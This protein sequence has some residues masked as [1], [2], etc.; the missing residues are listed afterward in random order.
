MSP[1][2]RAAVPPCPLAPTYKAHLPCLNATALKRVARLWVGKDASK[3]N[4]DGCIRAIN[5]GLQTPRAVQA[6]LQELTPFERAGLGLLKRY[7]QVAPTDALAAELLMLGIP[8]DER[9][10]GHRSWSV[11]QNVD[12]RALNALLQR[13]AAMMRSWQTSHGYPSDLQLDEYHYSAQ[14][15][16]EPCLLDG[17]DTVP[18]AP[19]P[20]E[21]VRQVETGLAQ[22]PAEVV[23]RLIGMVETLRKLGPI[24]RTAKGRISKPFLV[25][26]TKA[27]GWE[28]AMPQEALAPLAEATQFFFWLLSG[29][30][31]YAPRADGA[32]QL[33]P[34]STTLFATSYEVQAARWVG[35]YRS[36][37]GWVEYR[38]AGVWEEGGSERYYARFVGLRAALLLALAALPQPDAWYRMAELSAAMFSRVGE[39]VSLGYRPP[40]YLSY[41]AEPAKAEQERQNW[42]QQLQKSWERTES[43]WIMSA[44]RGPLVHLGLV[45]IAT[46]P[47]QPRPGASLFRLT[48]LGQAALYDALRGH[49]NPA[50]APSPTP[51][52]QAGRCWIVQPNFDVVVYLDRASATSLAFI[53]RIAARKPSSGATALYQMTR[54]TVYAALESGIEPTAL[55]ETLSA[56][57]TYPLPDNVRQMLEEWA[58]R[59]DRLTFYR[60]ASLLEFPDQASRDAVLASGTYTG[61]AVGERL[62]LLTTP[63]QPGRATPPPRRTVDYLAL[64]ARCLEVAEDGAVRLQPAQAD[65][66]VHGELTAWADPEQD[67]HHWRVSR[68]SIQRAVKAGW[69]AAYILHNLAQRALHSV[70]ALLEVAIRAW[71]GE[72]HAPRTVAVAADVLLQ[73]ADP[74]VAHAIA[75]STLLQPY[76]RG[77]LGPQ[78]FLV[79][80]E[81]AAVLQT[82]LDELGLQVGNDLL[83]T[84]PA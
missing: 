61:H 82:R 60:T 24:P 57:S 77:Q 72:R 13:G 3:L 62:L 84:A 40:F 55:H 22:Q 11:Q 46:A 8:F 16:S 20:L 15:F 34:E 58:A 37:T 63:L 79:H 74:K 25:K 69:T 28:E 76:L 83:L 66:L 35:A 43:P 4:K 53:E 45:E 26:L 81:A 1:W 38:P 36:L 73:V 56:A 44:L 75:T 47:R 23:L 41:R 67:D 9:G 10:R 27:L 33:T 68:T 52:S 7:G 21:P 70:P 59:R 48:L 17:V 14:V 19:L 32:L 51:A 54:D 42:L 39:Y 18:P 71:A 2:Y 5:A 64:P 31:F 6:A 78:T 49:Q 12:Y 29:L 30:D 50:P 80:R 65:L